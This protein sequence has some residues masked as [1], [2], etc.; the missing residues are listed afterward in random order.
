MSALAARLS[1][2]A[3]E[4]ENIRARLAAATRL[5]WESKAAE[6]FRQEAALRAAE[7]AA[8]SSEVRVAGDYVA[9]YARV[10]ESLAARGP[11][12]PGG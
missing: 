9:A 7:L 11:G 10:L 12:I 4:L 3:G 8:A 5:E 6:A 1:R 2:L